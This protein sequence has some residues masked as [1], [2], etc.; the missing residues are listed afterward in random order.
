[1]KTSKRGIE[2]IAS[3]EGFVD[4]PYRDTGGV[5]TIGYGHTGP[6]VSSMG[7]I[8]RARA[9]ELLARD[10]AAAEAAVNA[11]PVVLNQNQ[12][13]ATVSAAFNCGAGVLAADRSL[14]GALRRRDLSGVRAALAL[15][16]RDAR[17]NTLAGLVRRRRAE[18]DVFEK[19]VDDGPAAWLTP[20]ELRRCRELDRL[21][22]SA[23]PTPDE[24]RRIAVLVRALT[25]QRKRIWRSAQA[26]PKGD[27]RGW[28]HGHRHQRYESLRART[29]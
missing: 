25:K 9:L 5:W 26:A 22:D 29:A 23:H 15:Y 14:G 13:D 20:A 21:R 27:G 3:F 19:P 11:L 2:F 24:Q 6:G 28:D 17:G 10:V 16:T 1:M 7:R 18:A 4:H 12:F 8:T